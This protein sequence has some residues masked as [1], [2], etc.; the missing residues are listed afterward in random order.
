MNICFILLFSINLIGSVVKSTQTNDNE[1]RGRS[2]FPRQQDHERTRSLSSQTIFDSISAR[3]SKSNENLTQSISQ[4]NPLSISE[5]PTRERITK[6]EDRQQL[7]PSAVKS[8]TPAQIQKF[9]LLKEKFE[10]QLPIDVVFG[11]NDS[12]SFS[13]DISLFYYSKFSTL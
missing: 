12:L 6:S 9:N 7:L 4:Q 13:K 8:L 1:D 11:M 10:R 2:T 3:L 5:Q